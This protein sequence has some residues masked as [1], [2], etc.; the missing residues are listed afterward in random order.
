[1]KKKIA[2]Q[3]YKSLISKWQALPAILA[4]THIDKTGN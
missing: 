1:M 4:W 3:N 2:K